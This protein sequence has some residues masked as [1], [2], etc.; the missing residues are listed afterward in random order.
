MPVK[1]RMY[2]LCGTFLALCLLTACGGD[3]KVSDQAFEGVVNDYEG[4]TMTAVEGTAHPGTVTV[5]ILNTTDQDIESGNEY[6]FALQKEMNGTWYWL[7]TKQD[8]Y[9][10]TAE[11]LLYPEN[12]TVTQKLTWANVYGSLDKGHYRV[13]KAFFEYGGPGDSVD[14]LL[15]AEFD[16]E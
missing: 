16:I 7:Q 12:E 2:L 5:E 11:A 13:V 6:D 8:E 9:A 15:A 3:A 10:N 1:Y 4:V 14:F